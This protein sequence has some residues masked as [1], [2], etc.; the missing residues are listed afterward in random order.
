MNKD[1]VN[2]DLPHDKPGTFTGSSMIN[3]QRSTP[4]YSVWQLLDSGLRGQGPEST[5]SWLV[6]QSVENGTYYFRIRRL[7]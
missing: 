5:T 2:G 3:E 6:C 4:S 1:L 7:E